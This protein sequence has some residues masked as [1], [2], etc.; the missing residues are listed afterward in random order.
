MYSRSSRPVPLQGLR[1]VSP[2]L[3]V[4]LPS[5]RPDPSAELQ[6]C[7]KHTGFR[8][9]ETRKP[10][11]SSSS[12]GQALSHP[13]IPPEL[14]KQVQEHP[15]PT[16]PRSQQH[17]RGFRERETGRPLSRER[18]AGAL[19]AEEASFI[20]LFSLSLQA[21]TDYGALSVPMSI[22]WS[23]PEENRKIVELCE[24]RNRARSSS[25]GSPPGEESV[26]PTLPAKGY[27][28]ISAPF[29]CPR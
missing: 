6:G 18:S 21:R 22:S 4:R 25:S 2:W 28:L 7:D 23:V 17:S 16:A 8:L 26:R 1:G 12:P 14:M 5:L 24:R 19:P 20:S 29:G 11:N 15:F 9:P 13:Q 10:I 27:R 3:A